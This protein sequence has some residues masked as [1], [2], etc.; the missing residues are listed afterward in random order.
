MSSGVDNAWFNCKVT[1]FDGCFNLDFVPQRNIFQPWQVEINS[2]FLRTELRRSAKLIHF[3]VHNRV[4]YSF[5]V[6]V[7]D[8]D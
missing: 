6:T 8:K 2:A 5:R 7:V 3:L 4:D 1:A